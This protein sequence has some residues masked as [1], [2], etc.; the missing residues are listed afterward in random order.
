MRHAFLPVISFAALFAGCG[1]SSSSGSSGSMTCKDDGTLKGT[2]ERGQYL[3]DKLLVCGDCH[4][5][6]GSDGKPAATSENGAS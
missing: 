1:S 6:S 5:P 4:T 2:V 3:V